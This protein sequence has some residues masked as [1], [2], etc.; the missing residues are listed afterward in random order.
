MVDVGSYTPSAGLI[1]ALVDAALL[2]GTCN[3]Y[4]ASAGSTSKQR[5]NPT[6]RW[7]RGLP[8]ARRESV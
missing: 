6:S 8:A 7:P 2:G 5:P 1:G 3:G 4:S